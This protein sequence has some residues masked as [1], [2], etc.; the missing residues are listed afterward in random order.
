MDILIITG[1]TNEKA[2]L[3]TRNNNTVHFKKKNPQKICVQCS[4]T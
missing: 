2:W 4:E 3:R 1:D